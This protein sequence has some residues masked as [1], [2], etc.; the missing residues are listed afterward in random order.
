MKLK[1]F[2][3]VQRYFN[4]IRLVRLCRFMRRFGTKIINFKSIDSTEYK[5]IFFLIIFDVRFLPFNYFSH[6]SL[7]MDLIF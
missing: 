5:V 7:W 3:P 4:V 6:R 1:N 2:K